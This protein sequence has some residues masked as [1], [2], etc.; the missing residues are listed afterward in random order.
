[1]TIEWTDEDAIAVYDAICGSI[2]ADPDGIAADT[3][4]RI[5]D[6]MEPEMFAAADRVTAKGAV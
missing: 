5:R 2:A 3:L 4:R 6:A 1:M